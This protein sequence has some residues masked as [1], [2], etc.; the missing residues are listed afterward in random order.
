MHLLRK[1]LWKEDDHDTQPLPLPDKPRGIA[2]RTRASYLGACKPHAGWQC[3]K[4]SG[5]AEFA[6]NFNFVPADEYLVGFVILLRY[7]PALTG[8]TLTKGWGTECAGTGGEK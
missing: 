1:M 3:L 8:R 7:H 6:D 2:I 5:T 4:T